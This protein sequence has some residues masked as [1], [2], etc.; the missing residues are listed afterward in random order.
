MTRTISILPFL[1]IAC[2]PQEKP[3]DQQPTK[4]SVEAT[5]TQQENK[6]SEESSSTEEVG[7][8]LPVESDAETDDVSS[9]Q[10]EVG[11]GESLVLLS[12]WAD[13]SVEA[14]GELNG[15][16]V[17]DSIYPGQVLKLPLS[18][19]AQI[20]AF[21]EARAQGHQDRLDRYLGS[22]GGLVDVDF[23]IVRTGETAWQ[24]AQDQTGIPLWVLA[25]FNTDTD[26]NSL[27]IGQPLHVPV[28]GDTVAVYEVEELDSI[29]IETI[30]LPIDYD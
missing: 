3:V 18:D 13:S 14:I 7:Y 12:S 27:G 23:H 29:Q 15:L 30:G 28:L 2:G 9:W 11:M 22:R 4:K 24:I 25:S 6:T 1:L 20:D 16:D 17:R 19:D 5:K 10:T 21:R 8:S 26:L